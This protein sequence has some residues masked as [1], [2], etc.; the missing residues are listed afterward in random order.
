MCLSM[1]NEVG[2]DIYILTPI[3]YTMLKIGI[4]GQV[5]SNYFCR[6]ISSKYKN[7]YMETPL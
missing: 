2:Y 1:L 4:L 5:N 7:I 6:N 3:F